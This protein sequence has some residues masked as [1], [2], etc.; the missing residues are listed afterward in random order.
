MKFA[1][2]TC[3]LGLRWIIALVLLC[4]AARTA[5]RVRGKQ[6]SVSWPELFPRAVIDTYVEK[7]VPCSLLATAN[8]YT[9]CVGA[10]KGERR[11]DSRRSVQ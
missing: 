4:G 8:N 1:V 6:Q 10:S 9:S 3:H 11:V 7:S 2:S 5:L